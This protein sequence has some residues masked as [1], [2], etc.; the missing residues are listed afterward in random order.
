MATARAAADSTA[1][2]LE[3]LH[4]TARA[5]L[6]S[7]LS[8]QTYD[9]LYKALRE[10]ILNGIDADASKI[11]IDLGLDVDEDEIVV[12]DDGEGMDLEGLRRS[13]MSLGGSEKFNDAE[14]FGRIGIGSLALLTYA[15]EG[16]VET[17]RSGSSEVVEAHLFHPQDL[18][19]EQRSQR[20]EDFAAGQ[21]STRTYSG[22]PNDHFTRIRL[23]GLASE[24][25]SVIREAPQFYA[26]VD[27]LTRVLPLPL[28][29]S[30]L[31][32]SLAEEDADL[33]DLLSQ[34]AG[35]WS[36]PITVSSPIHENLELRKRTFGDD[37]SEEW[38]GRIQPIHRSLRIVRPGERREIV[39]A[40]FF[41]NQLKAVPSWSGLTA[42]VQ[43]VAVEE[44]TFFDVQTDPGF[45]KYIAGE[46]F[47]MGDVHVDR[48][49]N[50]NRTSFNKESRDYQLTQRFVG[51]EI[52]N[53]KRSQIAMGQ[54]RKVE[55]RK[56]V[57]QYRLMLE[58]VERLFRRV[59]QMAPIASVGR[60][61]PSSKN[62]S[63]SSA[64]KDG[65]KDRVKALGARFVVDKKRTSTS[66][67]LIERPANADRLTVRIAERLASPHAEVRGKRYELSLRRGR[68]SG[69]AVI[70]KN[71]PREIVFNTGHPAVGEDCTDRQ[72][73]QVLALEL[74]FLLS[75]GGDAAGLYELMLGFIAER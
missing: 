15:R 47:L 26:L 66:G 22:D 63:L 30:R 16:I 24:A 19:R 34:H 27:Q 71:R 65:I 49:I 46:V 40:G 31:V 39:V 52:E 56:V 64:S 8:R 61:L 29:E 11:R 58:G 48:L 57:E 54:R 43:N 17:K 60:G 53:F 9:S 33:V 68:P 75:N 6:L 5:G 18:D 35:Q 7:E 51:D 45:R 38:A 62:G 44:R 50:I 3:P 23:V 67:Y 41:V 55:V 1:I 37:P 59:D 69:P 36:V 42:R 72:A 14:K 21:V 2:D 20:L 12:S 10:A 74:A 4:Y 13:F 73:S 32:E 70:V 25:R 28:G